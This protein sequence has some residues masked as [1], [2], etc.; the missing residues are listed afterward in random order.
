[1]LSVIVA[2]ADGGV[3]GC[4][5]MMPWH[6]S[7]DLRMFKRVTMGRPVVMGRRTFESLGRPLPGRINVVIT[8]NRDRS[9]PGTTCVGSLDEALA[10]FPP[11]DEVFVIGGGEIYRQAMPRADRFYLT[12]VHAAYDGDTTF[13]EW[14][15]DEWTLV[16]SECH[17]HGTDF[18]HPFE[19]LV[20]E[21]QLRGHDH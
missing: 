11:D 1:M 19:F 8:R 21:R 2:V 12:R 3:I 7:E 5:G 4:K 14:N 16:S 15:P 20:Y 17:E 10:M 13:P 6:I 18:P 9:I